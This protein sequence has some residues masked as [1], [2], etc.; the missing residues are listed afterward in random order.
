MTETVVQDSGRDERMTPWSVVQVLNF[1]AETASGGLHH[2]YLAG[3]LFPITPRSLEHQILI[4]L[5]PKLDSS[6]LHRRP[7]NRCRPE[8]VDQ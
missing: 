5:L 6:S 7:L 3:P 4:A 8:P 2:P 1:L